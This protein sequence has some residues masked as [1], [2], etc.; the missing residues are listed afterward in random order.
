MDSQSNSQLMPPCPFCGRG[1][2]KV[3]EVTLQHYERTVTFMCRA[4]DQT[5]TSTDNLQSLSGPEEGPSLKMI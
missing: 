2:G 4:C 5:W 1:Y 3:N